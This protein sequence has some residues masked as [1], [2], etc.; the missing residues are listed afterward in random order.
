MSLLT[1]TPCKTSSRSPHTERCYGGLPATFH[2]QQ[3]ASKHHSYKPIGTLTSSSTSPKLP[4]QLVFYLPRFSAAASNTLEQPRGHAHPHQKHPQTMSMQPP[5]AGHNH[6]EW[7]RKL[8]TSER[9]RPKWFS[10]SGP[11][12]RGAAKSSISVAACHV[13]KARLPATLYG[14]DL[15]NLRPAGDQQRDLLHGTTAGL[16]IERQ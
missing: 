7:R 2:I 12:R 3:S 16:I 1:V 8:P 11:L 5:S 14:R 15:H 6:K 9:G 4:P 10:S 13:P